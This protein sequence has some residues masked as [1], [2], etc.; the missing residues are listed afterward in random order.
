[1]RCGVGFDLQAV[2]FGVS[3]ARRGPGADDVASGEKGV[4]CR[5]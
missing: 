1:M 5:A 4:C 2:D 3:G